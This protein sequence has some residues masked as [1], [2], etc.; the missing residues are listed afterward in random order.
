MCIEG[1]SYL[2]N[3]YL[4]F[5]FVLLFSCHIITYSGVASNKII[6]F[7]NKNIFICVI[8]LAWKAFHVLICLENKVQIED[9][10]FCKASMKSPRC[11]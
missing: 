9:C 6:I 10:R 3:R 5:G 1:S 8:R 7:L 2:T 11:D 4:F